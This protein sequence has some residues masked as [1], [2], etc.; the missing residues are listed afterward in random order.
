MAGERRDVQWYGNRGEALGVAY[1]PLV[2]GFCVVNNAALRDAVETD[3][4]HRL[5]SL[6][7]MQAA[8]THGSDPR[9]LDCDEGCGRNL[10]AT[11]AQLPQW[12][13]PR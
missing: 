2:C 5:Q 10:I 7:A 8:E 13:R 6:D 9:L 1:G 3:R 12:W 4:L 11:C